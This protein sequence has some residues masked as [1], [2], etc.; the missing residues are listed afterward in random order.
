M[1]KVI[2]MTYYTLL[3]TLGMSE[4]QLRDTYD[5]PKIKEFIALIMSS[6]SWDY[7]FWIGSEEDE[8]QKTKGATKKVMKMQAWLD[9]NARKISAS[10]EAVETPTRGQAKSTTRFND[11]PQD[12]GNFE[13]DPHTTNFTAF[14][15]NDAVGSD[16]VVSL[17][18]R[19]LLNR[20]R[21]EF[22][23]RFIIA[24]D[25]LI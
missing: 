14:T 10:L 17:N 2:N 20:Y 7:A 25:S 5:L 9:A 8:Q 24:E 15:S 3:E 4:L 23:K 19:D 12:G 11:T 1:Q 16:Y 21:E 22:A 18:A 6:F 13:D